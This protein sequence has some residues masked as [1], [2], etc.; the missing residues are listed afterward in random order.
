MPNEL[1][2][3]VQSPPENVAFGIRF[4]SEWTGLE[5]VLS[6]EILVVELEPKILGPDRPVA[7]DHVLDTTASSPTPVEILLR[8]VD[9]A[10]PTRCNV[11]VIDYRC[12]P[13]HADA[14]ARSIEQPMTPC[15]SQAAANRRIKIALAL[16]EGIIAR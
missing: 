9:E 3:I 6:A 16:A 14:T 5:I 11:T 15:E 12:L 1:E 8:S 10:S 7:A 4:K 13:I 2:L